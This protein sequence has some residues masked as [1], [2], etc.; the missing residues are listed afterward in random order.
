MKTKATL[1]IV[2]FCLI[3]L[4][5]YGSDFLLGAYL[6]NK[7]TDDEVYHKTLCDSMRAAGY[8]T[9]ICSA[10]DETD[11]SG[12]TDMLDWM[13][14][15]GI[16]AI[17][18]DHLF[19]P[20]ATPSVYG[21]KTL[22]TG[23]YFVFEA[24]YYDDVSLSDG[25]NGDSSM[26]DNFFYMSSYSDLHSD[27]LD[28]VRVGQ[29]IRSVYY[30]NQFYWFVENGQSGYAYY[31]LTYKWPQ[32]NNLNQYRRIG[33]DFRFPNARTGNDDLYNTNVLYITY[34]MGCPNAEALPAGTVMA[35]IS[36]T[37]KG[38]YTNSAVPVITI[39][40]DYGTLT[41]CETTY[42][43]REM[44]LNSP[45]ADSLR[46]ITVT[47]NVSALPHESVLINFT[48]VLVNLNPHLYWRGH[49]S[50]KLDYIKFED[51]LHR[52]Y[53]D[54]NSVLAQM[55]TFNL[56]YLYGY[57]EPTQAQFESFRRINRYLEDH[58]I[59]T[60]VISFKNKQIEVVKTNYAIEDY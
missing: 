16:S 53:T 3:I 47:V 11:A 55:R 31:D 17:L 14:D 51:K 33:N 57:D 24:E 37:C 27:S 52:D 15:Y 44:Y 23:N 10:V 34:A 40:H 46:L 8:N 41:D 59:S 4:S 1:L 25:V 45:L 18:E 43:T 30:S 35:E 50:L 42:L 38:M 22:S 48:K 5:A 36:L 9:A 58:D 60:Q 21:A 19:D 6:Y 29:P 12:V 20:F 56:P 54:N 2:I 28:T 13:G 49:G 7:N 26:P 32:T 39:P